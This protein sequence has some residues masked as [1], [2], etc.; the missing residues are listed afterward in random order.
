MTSLAPIAL[1]AYKRPSHTL[2]TLASLADNPQARQSTLHIFCDGAKTPRDQP[3]VDEVRRIVRQRQWCG[4]V[5]I[6]EQQHNQGLANS[7]IHGVT[8]LVNE[9]GTVIVLEDDLQLAPHCL[10]FMN[11]SLVR[12]R[13]ATRVMQVTGYLFPA[14]VPQDDDACFLP[15][16][17][18]WGWATWKRAW[19]H[20]DPGMSNLER[21]A[22]DAF[23]RYHFDLEG[24][25]RFYHMLEEQRRGRIDSWAV[26]WYLSV[27]SQNGLTVFP[28]R[29]LIRNIG[30]DGTGTHCGTSEVFETSLWQHK[31]TRFPARVDLSRAAYQGLQ[32]YFRH[33]N[34][35]QRTASNAKRQGRRVTLR[36]AL[37]RLGLLRLARWTLKGAGRGC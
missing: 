15:M 1:F 35:P 19:D 24:T 22:H 6:I 3:L 36:R 7:I 12:Y 28:T 34:R 8:Q 23:L 2:Q 30:F 16:C 11:D 33:I 20:F 17:S 32:E 10:E 14:R 4:T 5:H 18:S 9:H 13:D 37:E 27:F 29:S 25:H 31:L 21:L 26:R